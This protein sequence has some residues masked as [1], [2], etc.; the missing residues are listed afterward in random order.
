[1]L[2]TEQKII[3]ELCWTIHD[4]EKDVPLPPDSRTCKVLRA[5]LFS[6]KSTIAKGTPRRVFIQDLAASLNRKAMLPSEKY[7][8]F[9]ELGYEYMVV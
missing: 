5:A 3:Q 6:A 7:D 9:T 2:R 1:M 8:N 4:W